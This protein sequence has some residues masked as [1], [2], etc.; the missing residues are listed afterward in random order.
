MRVEDLLKAKGHEVET[1]KPESMRPL[2]SQRV[3]VASTDDS[4]TIRRSGWIE[5]RGSDDG[6]VVQQ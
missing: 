1:I 2:L 5:R 4:Y 6:A 3:S